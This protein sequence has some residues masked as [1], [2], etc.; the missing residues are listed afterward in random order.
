[1]TYGDSAVLLTLIEAHARA[2][3]EQLASALAVE[4]QPDPILR[5]GQPIPQMTNKQLSAAIF[6]QHHASMEKLRAVASAI[7]AAPVEAAPHHPTPAVAGRIGE[8]LNGDGH[9]AD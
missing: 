5:P 3:R 8:F 2:A 9:N 4:R 6:K 7:F 1:M